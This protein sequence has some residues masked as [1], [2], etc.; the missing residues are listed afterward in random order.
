[1]DA[2]TLPAAQLIEILEAPARAHRIDLVGAVAL[3]RGL[4]HGPD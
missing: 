1:M 3:P 2:P 4:D